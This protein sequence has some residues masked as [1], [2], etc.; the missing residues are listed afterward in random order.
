MNASKQQASAIIQQSTSNVEAL[1]RLFEADGLPGRTVAQ[2]L[3]WILR[4]T[5]SG[6]PGMQ[7][8]LFPPDDS[9]F[10]EE[11]ADGR[12]Y[13]S[14]LYWAKL[15]KPERRNT[16]QMGHFLIAVGL[17]VTPWPR[18]VALRLIVGHEKL[19]DGLFF[20]FVRQYLRATAEDRRLFMEAVDHDQ[21]GR[22][23]QRDLALRKIF[24]EPGEAR[25]DPRR[26]GNSVPDLRLSVK[27]WRF[28]QAIAERRLQTR[29]EAAAWLRRE[30][31]DPGRPRQPVPAP[32]EPE[33]NRA[34]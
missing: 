4:V 6:L 24:G 22:S 12:F 14:R 29:A 16:S 1:M 8:A 31:Y 10:K 7:M 5:A 11:L 34:E 25:R 13:F 23:R 26:I 20:G 28:G 15:V 21:A 27:G 2:R 32:A 30:I 3:R 9:G 19:G 18:T 17:R 33:T